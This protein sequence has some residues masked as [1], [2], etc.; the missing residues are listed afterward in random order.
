MKLG[1]I[2]VPTP[3]GAQARIVALTDDGATVV[4]L[5]V[6]YAGLLRS[7]G[8]DADGARRLARAL[9]P[10]S[11]SAAIG[12][13]DAFLDAARAALDHADDASTPVDSVSWIAAV[14]PPVIR[15]GLTYPTHMQ[16]FLQKVGAKPDPQAFKT[17][18]F[19]KGSVSRIYGT[20]EVLPYP[21][22]TE[23]LDWEFEIGIVVGRHGHNLTAE[24]AASNIFGYTIFNDWSARDVQ[25][26][27]M[28]MGM[29]PQK[30]KDFAFGIGPVIVTAD[31]LPGIDD[32]KGEV[33]VNGEVVSKVESTPR[34]FSSAEM[35]AWVSVGDAVLPGDLI[36]TGTMGFGSGFELDL[37]L[38]PGD[39]LELDL[40]KVGVL[41]TPVGEVEQAPWWPEEKPFAWDEKW[42]R[43]GY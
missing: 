35:V 11:M 26:R 9:F 12:S 17:P 24:Q 5:A 42:K 30:C 32:L 38:S 1:R 29:G 28:A 43:T 40:E 2:S 15:D 14:D 18:P 34:I 37:R 41:R 6:A 20:D 22:Y 21:H 23:Y 19:F 4:D 7:R 36:G 31:E 13:G 16:N 27:E 39:V 3:D 25:A 10:A 8:A 33:R